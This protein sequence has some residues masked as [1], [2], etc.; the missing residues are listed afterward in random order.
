MFLIIKLGLGLLN[1]DNIYNSK[2]NILEV[3]DINVF[4]NNN[5]F[6]IMNVHVGLGDYEFNINNIY[7]NLYA[8]WLK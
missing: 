5:I 4:W 1:I 7:Y 8:I 3:N 6:I 2:I